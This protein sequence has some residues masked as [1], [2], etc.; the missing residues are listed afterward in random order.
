MHLNKSLIGHTNIIYDS[1]IL[2]NKADL[3]SI[4]EDRSVKRWNLKDGNLLQTYTLTIPAIS[5]ISIPVDFVNYF[6]VG[7]HGMIVIYNYSEGVDNI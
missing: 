7:G 6:I 2:Y 5:I 4:S 3:L 1:V